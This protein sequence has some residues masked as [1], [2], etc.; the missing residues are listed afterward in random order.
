[1]GAL[2]T[3]FSSKHAGYGYG[4]GAYNYYSYGSKEETKKLGRR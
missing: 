1:V 3:K 2:L 4:Y